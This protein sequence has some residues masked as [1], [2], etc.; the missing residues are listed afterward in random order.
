MPELRSSSWPSS[1]PSS[2]L[3]LRSCSVICARFLQLESCCILLT[4]FALCVSYR[5]VSHHIASHRIA[6]HRIASHCIAL[7]RI[8]SHRIESH[9]IASH[10]VT[11]RFMQFRPDETHGLE[12]Q[13]QSSHFTMEGVERIKGY[14][15]PAPGS[16]PEANVPLSDE[17]V[18]PFDINYLG[19]DTRRNSE[20]TNLVYNFVNAQEA[21][22]LKAEGVED[23]VVIG[24]DVSISSLQIGDG[25]EVAEKVNDTMAQ[26]LAPQERL[27]SKGNNGT[28]ATGPSAVIGANAKESDPYALRSSMGAT[29]EGMQ[30]SLANH[31]PTQLMEFAWEKDSDRIVAEWEAKGLPPV[32]GE[33]FGWKREAKKYIASW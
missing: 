31:E 2:W 19:K 18:D 6:L 24:P 28:F 26:I 25:G 5:I 11:C 13:P 3:S 1:W 32:P 7:H 23:M 29:H 30:A 22:R 8:A 10:R 21:A 27:G 12:G 17:G 33:T 14:R 16:R 20:R 9:R 4:S 15:Y